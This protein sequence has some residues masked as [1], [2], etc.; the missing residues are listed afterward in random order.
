VKIDLLAGE[1][2]MARLHELGGLL[3]DAV[4]NGA[5][6]G[7]TLPLKRGEV[8]GYWQKVCAEVAAEHRLLFAALDDT[9]RIIGS[10]QLA[11]EPRANGRHR[12]EVQKVMVLAAHRRHRLGAALMAR[13]EAEAR[14][15]GRT[16]LFLDTS[17]GQA[18]ATEFYERLGY[19]YAG[20]IPDFAANPDGTLVAN[21]IYYKRLAARP[22][23]AAGDW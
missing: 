4:G 1:N 9:G 5:S 10:A 18:G 6:V 14:T 16:L 2:A 15:R 21:A 11:L 23:G 19:T 8:A 12:A 13:I 20:G 7:F 17:V 3:L 22:P